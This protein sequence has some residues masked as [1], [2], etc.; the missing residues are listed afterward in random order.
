MNMAWALGNQIRIL[1]F[2]CWSVKGDC[3]G[4]WEICKLK[5]LHCWKSMK[6]WWMAEQDVHCLHHKSEKDEVLVVPAF[7]QNY[8]LFYN[9][10]ILLNGSPDASTTL[11]IFND[12]L[13][14]KVLYWSYLLRLIIKLLMYWSSRHNYLMCINKEALI[15]LLLYLIFTII[16]NEDHK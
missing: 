16:L 2:L 7:N 5:I 9:Y 12:H 10:L 3:F 4:K 15:P 11:I 14:F 6:W 8:K 1:F 13:L